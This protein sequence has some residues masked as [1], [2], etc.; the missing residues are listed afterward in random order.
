MAKQEQIDSL[1][2]Y[3]SNKYVL[4]VCAVFTFLVRFEIYCLLKG[5]F[6]AITFDAISFLVNQNEV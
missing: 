4:V 6:V 5:A 1:I 3:T 2:Y